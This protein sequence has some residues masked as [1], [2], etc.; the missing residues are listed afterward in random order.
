MAKKLDEWH[1]VLNRSDIDELMNEF[2]GFHDSC[3]VA[4]NYVSGMYV[5]SENAMYSDGYDKYALV[6]T[7]HSQWCDFALELSFTGLRSLHLVGAQDNYSNDIL[8]A[9]INFYDELLPCEYVAPKRVI[10]WADDEHFDAHDIAEPL[11]EPNDTYV[12]AHSLKWRFVK[13]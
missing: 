3:I 9:S 7:F 13:K 10:V 11:K 1:E 4:L 5:D 12:V 2:G 8:G 6:M